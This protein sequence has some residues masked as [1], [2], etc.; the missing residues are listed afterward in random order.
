MILA[1]CAKCGWRGVD[2]HCSKELVECPRCGRPVVGLS[3]MFEPDVVATD[4]TKDEERERDMRDGGDEEIEAVSMTRC[5]RCNHEASSKE[6]EGSKCPECGSGC[7][8]QWIVDHPGEVEV[9]EDGEVEVYEDGGDEVWGE[10][11]E[12][13]GWVTIC[14]GCGWQGDFER[15]MRERGPRGWECPEC[16][17]G[18][19]EAVRV[20]DGE[21]WARKERA[22]DAMP[23]VEAFPAGG[24][25]RDPS[26]ADVMGAYDRLLEGRAK[27][28]MLDGAVLAE[29]ERREP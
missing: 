20:D 10:R 13:R 11:I 19:G 12:A 6:W 24:T 22:E 5:S 4:E 28:R 18:V 29:R 23:D 2:E 27:D 7:A 15:D 17:W 8:L 9:F 25:T 26:W 14:N 21:V 1:R 16:G 3:I